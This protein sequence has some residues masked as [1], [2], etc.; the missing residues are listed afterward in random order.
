MSAVDAM[1]NA[2]VAR[3][4]RT[5][6]DRL[7]ARPLRQQRAIAWGLLAVALISTVAAIGWP[8]A[9]SILQHR[10]WRAE[11]L[12]SL[13]RDRGFAAAKASLLRT[14]E[15]LAAHPARTFIYA[16]AVGT[17]EGLLRGEVQ[18]LW[19]RAGVAAPELEILPALHTRESLTRISVKGA[20]SASVDQWL[21]F[22]D[23]IERS[24]HLIVLDQMSVSS[25]DYQPT[26]GN[27]ALAIRFVA[28]AFV[29]PPA[30]N[31]G[32]ASTA[33]TSGSGART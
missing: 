14:Q 1:T 9:N 20:V 30:D 27:A 12:T 2:A 31:V 11:A 23:Q 5:W 24:S 17:A 32:G 18:G 15:S 25:P 4:V 8:L 21:R 13:A 33:D 16:E 22:L 28:H 7:Q 3:R 19:S 26:D 10:A 6:L 29:H